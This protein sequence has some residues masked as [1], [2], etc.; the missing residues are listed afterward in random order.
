MKKINFKNY[1]LGLFFLFTLFGIFF[2]SPQT[3]KATSGIYLDSTG[4]SYRQNSDDGSGNFTFSNTIG[5]SCANSF[6]MAFVSTYTDG[7]GWDSVSY[8]GVQMTDSGIGGQAYVGQVRHMRW[9]TFVLKSPLSGTRNFHVRNT[10]GLYSD[11]A[12]IVLKT[13]CNV[14]QTT[15]LDFVRGGVSNYSG[16]GI[17]SG[18]FN[19]TNDNSLVLF[20]YIL[21]TGGTV[22]GTAGYTKSSLNAYEYAGQQIYNF[23]TATVGSK[24]Q[25]D[26]YYVGGTDTD[27]A[28]S[29]DLFVLN[30]AAPTSN[31]SITSHTINQASGDV[32]INGICDTIGTGQNQLDIFAN[33]QGDPKLFVVDC[34]NNG[35]S[36][37][38]P[39]M[40]YGT[41]TIYVIDALNNAS[42]NRAS[43]TETRNRPPSNIEIMYPEAS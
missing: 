13:F 5:S 43:F 23:F 2:N 17:G 26:Y 24:T 30:A 32:S 11:P 12:T 27:W 4:Y 36:A 7:A 15:P 29:L 1:L 6:L 22:T 20:N 9:Q 28:R 42:L 3:V 16:N 33:S 18:Y 31:I 19:I 10:R 25:Y 37:V 14:D 41:S 35:F 8:G 21:A 34:L 39:S 38:Y 40:D